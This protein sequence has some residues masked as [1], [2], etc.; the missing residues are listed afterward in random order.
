MGEKRVQASAKGLGKN[1][2]AYRNMH[3]KYKNDTYILKKYNSLVD[4]LILERE[5]KDVVSWVKLPWRCI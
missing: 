5:T 4:D 2:C 1:L 3:S